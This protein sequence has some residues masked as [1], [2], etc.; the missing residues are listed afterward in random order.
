[1]KRGK[2]TGVCKG[3]SSYI[4]HLD[5]DTK[6]T[7]A[8][9]HLYS[10]NWEIHGLVSGPS[11]EFYAGRPQEISRKT[12]LPAIASLLAFRALFLSS[13]L[14]FPQC[15]CFFLIVYTCKVPFSKMAAEN[16]NKLKLKTYT[17]TRK[18]TFTLV[19]SQSFF[20]S[21]VISAQKM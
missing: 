8:G 20:I 5:W 4:T 3:N 6:G 2:R 18:S 21:V 16:S 13:V 1:M 19:T 12:A 7:C 14:F 11:A 10:E 17:S 9:S 15:W